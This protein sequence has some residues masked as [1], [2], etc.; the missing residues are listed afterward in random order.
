MPGQ[1]TSVSV[2]SGDNPRHTDDT[3]PYLNALVSLCID[4]IAV[5]A[6]RL[7]RPAART[8]RTL[9]QLWADRTALALF[10]AGLDMIEPL[11]GLWS[12]RR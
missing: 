4:Q 11:F 6:H 10:V 1:S 7:N 12:C 2:T 5:G 3:R 8:D 9:R